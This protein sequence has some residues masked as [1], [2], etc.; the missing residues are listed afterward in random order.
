M[1]GVQC[2]SHLFVLRG[3][4]QGWPIGG[5]RGAR[6][7]LFSSFLVT[8]LLGALPGLAPTWQF[9]ST[10][11]ES[12]WES[13]PSQTHQACWA[14]ASP[15]GLFR[16][17]LTSLFP[18]PSTA[19]FPANSATE[20]PFNL[21]YSKSTAL[22][23]VKIL[24][25]DNCVLRSGAAL[26]LH[27]SQVRL[28]GVPEMLRPLGTTWFL[29]IVWDMISLYGLGWSGTLDPH[30]PVSRVIESQAHS[31]YASNMPVGLCQLPCW[32]WFAPELDCSS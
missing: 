10:Q 16:Q 29:F 11:K 25:T 1:L 30:F 2:Y 13:L 21:S 20:T 4:H 17:P 12:A 5:A 23:L 24:Y 6:C 31:I 22:Y 19:A 14:S 8:S 9:P 15:I 3:L 32:L 7:L 27:W 26:V 18:E 28:D